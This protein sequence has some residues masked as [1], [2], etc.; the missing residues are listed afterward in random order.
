[1]T[2][3]ESMHI[4]YPLRI[5]FLPSSEIYWLYILGALLIAL[6]LYML[7]GKNK[8]QQQNLLQY[9]FPKE[10]YLHPSAIAEYKYYFAASRLNIFLL[11]HFIHFQKN[12]K[13]LFII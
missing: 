11:I 3:L 7:D 2:Q 5:P 6:L 12:L 8:T 10:I 13:I 1:M 9:L 4:L